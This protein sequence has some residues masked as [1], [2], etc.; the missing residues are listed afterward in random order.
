VL[1]YYMQEVNMGRRGNTP[2]SCGY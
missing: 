2:R 1:K